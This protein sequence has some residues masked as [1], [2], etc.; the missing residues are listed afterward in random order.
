MLEK[1]PGDSFLN[2]ALALEMEKENRIPEAVALLEKTIGS[3]ENYLGA[4][5]KLASL[6][7]NSN[8]RLRSIAV[9]NKGIGVAERQ[10]NSKTLSELKELFARAGD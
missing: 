1:E 4:Y 6:L 5:Y 7:L 9:L 8:E 10:K 2:Y 3:D